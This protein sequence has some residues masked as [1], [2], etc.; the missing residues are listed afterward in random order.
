[1][2]T[3]STMQLHGKVVTSPHR[4]QRLARIHPLKAN[5]SVKDNDPFYRWPRKAEKSA[6]PLTDREM[7][8]LIYNFGR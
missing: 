8:H 3:I 1:M 6:K 5:K 7:D 2:K 4:S